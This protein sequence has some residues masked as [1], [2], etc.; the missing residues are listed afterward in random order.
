MTLPTNFQ[1]LSL[2]VRYN[3][4]SYRACLDCKY[5]IERLKEK[6]VTY[7]AWKVEWAGICALLRTSVHLMRE[8][9]A[10]SCLPEN[11]NTQMRVAW[12]ELLTN[13]A[14]YPLFW[15]FIHKERNNIMK[16]YEFSAYEAIIGPDG[17]SKASI[18]I[19]LLS[20]MEEGEKQALLIKSGHY[21][22]HHALELLTEAVNW[23]EAYILG[24]IRKAGYDPNERRQ[25]A[26]LLPVR[27]NAVGGITL[28][29]SLPP[30]KP[31]A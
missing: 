12:N 28:L 24:A 19:S 9:D 20:V 7:S 18:P 11:L 30:E 17:R 3:L 29:G 6:E 25:I 16:E 4:A 2:E 26:T 13:K 8:K 5:A 15:E 1:H 22:G 27:S 14:K 31:E 10:K 21:A 23:T